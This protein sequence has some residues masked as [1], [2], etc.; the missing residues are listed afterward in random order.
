MLKLYSDERFLPAGLPLNRLLTPFWGNPDGNENYSEFARVG[1]GFLEMTGPGEA[2]VAALPFEGGLLIDGGH[3]GHA[4][5]V[6]AGDRFF[7]HAR[8]FGLRTVVL[9]N[10]DRVTKVGGPGTVVF[11][12]SMDRRTRAGREHAMPAWSC[13]LF[14]RHG[15]GLVVRD[16]AAVPTV[17][18]CGVVASRLPPLTRRLRMFAR[19]AGRPL[20][21]NIPHRDGVY[22]RQAAMDALAGSGEVRTNFL[23]RSS[24]YGGDV[25]DPSLHDRARREYTENTLGSDYVL[26]VRGY[27]NFSFRFFE[28]MSLGRIPVLIDTDCVL[29]FDDLFD[30]REFCVVVPEARIGRVAEEVARFHARL[31]PEG[32]RGLQA[33]NRRFWEEWLSPE[34]FFRN[35]GRYLK[36]VGPGAA[37]ERPLGEGLPR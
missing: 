35:A 28:T 11:R 25:G 14:R 34:G 4:A 23:K 9:I 37:R 31:T 7:G 3:P 29:P 30:Y 33:R 5:A 20:G 6:E 26:C 2:D 1:R 12:T 32:F 27:G 15:G 36:R 19:R 10:N 24:Y 8:S 17:G 13:D 21:L 18:F 16:K 22:L